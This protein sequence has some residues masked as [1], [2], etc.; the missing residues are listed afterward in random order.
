[1]RHFQGGIAMKGQPRVF[2]RGRFAI[3]AGVIA[4]V[5]A[6]NHNAFSRTVNVKGW[7]SETGGSAYFSFD[8]ISH[9]GNPTGTASQ[10]LL[11]GTDNIGGR[12]T[13]QNIAEYTLDFSKSCTAPDGT[14]GVAVE[15]VEA[16]E[17]VT[18]IKGQLYSSAEGPTRG[19]ISDT[20]GVFT[21]T[22]T[23]T[24]FGGTGKFSNA[25]GSITLKL[26]GRILS[27]PASPGFGLF[28]A[29][30]ITETGSV[31]N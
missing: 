3:M 26:T 18:Y 7:A 13:G 28:G 25:S 4:C 21:E 24:V 19:C 8:G 14:A 31:T 1:M 5:I 12:F 6:S 30:A 16:I 23:H 10:L 15:L 27:A 9:P 22:E 11:A 2:I 29:A 17:A 20:T